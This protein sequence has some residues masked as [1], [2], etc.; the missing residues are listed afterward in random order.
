MIYSSALSRLFTTALLVVLSTMPSWANEKIRIAY[1]SSLTA[2]QIWVAKKQ[3]FFEKNRLDVDLVVIP[4][5]IALMSQMAGEL[6]YT[7]FGTSVPG[8]VLNGAPLKIVMWLYDRIDYVLVAQPQ[9]KT[10][11]SLKGK[12][13]GISSYNTSTHD[14]VRVIFRAHGID[15]DKEAQVIAMGRA[16]LR[17]QS[18]V[19]GKMD[20]SVFP[21]PRDFFA[22]EK[23][24]TLLD[25]VRDKLDW[26]MTGVTVTNKKLATNRDQ[27]RRVVQSIVDATRFYRENKEASIRLIQDWL[28]L[29]RS[30]A[31]KS[32]NKSLRHIS[33]DG[34]TRER[35]ISNLI[36][37]TKK[38]LK[39]PGEY[40]ISMFVDYAI[41]QEVLPKK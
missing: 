16:A 12:T 24:M 11:E 9:F 25:D 4:T 29:P 10:V 18:L 7:I 31:E 26:P 35:A 2:V 3:G 37:A 23:G 6:D 14:A 33:Y 38:D 21:S 39:K 15:V 28:A 20:A 8:A 13:I 32:Y 5:E 36:D 41:L 22:E 34:R 19:V 17:F 30:V 40:P 1:P 27:V